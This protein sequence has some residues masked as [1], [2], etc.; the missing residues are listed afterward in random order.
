MANNLQI[1][2]IDKN[3]E[4]CCKNEANCTS[5]HLAPHFL[6][7]K[8][9]SFDG[10]KGREREIVNFSMLNELKNEISVGR[11][12]SDE[13]REEVFGH[14][15]TGEE[16]DANRNLLVRDYIFCNDCEDRFSK[17]ENEYAKWY[18]GKV[19]ELSPR[20]SFLFWMSVIWRMSVG[21]MSILMDIQQEIAL[22]EIL[23]ANL[24]KDVSEI[25]NST[26]N[27][28]TSGYVLSRCLDMQNYKTGI[29]GIPI[30]KSPYDLVINDLTVE[31]YFDKK[32]YLDD[33]YYQ[34]RI[35]DGYV[36]NDGTK[37]EQCSDISLEQ[38]KGRVK[39]IIDVTWDNGIDP[40]RD[41]VEEI[42]RV[43]EKSTDIK[44]DS[45][46]VEEII[47]ECKKQAKP[48]YAMRI[49]AKLLYA[50]AKSEEHR[51]NGDTNYS[52]FEDNELG[53][54]I[55]EVLDFLHRNDN[56]FDNEKQDVSQIKKR[57]KF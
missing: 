16:I 15:M 52:I 45:S 47:A 55:N 40:N 3:C 42:F 35:K 18:N 51:K 2:K 53:I 12:V 27:L 10:K 22:R 28:G 29:L 46:I 5:S 31:Y 8:S 30:S 14:P 20:I 48:M 57:K 36:I 11:G 54:T 23:N 34:Q 33:P 26:C 21:R 56:I 41:H 13:K 1:K 9:F 32:E 50:M 49:P 39:Y 43:I 17:I 19:K 44:V 7:Q 25:M 4:L 6:I 24:S 38:L 37:P